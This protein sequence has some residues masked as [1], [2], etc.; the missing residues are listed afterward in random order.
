MIGV[1]SPGKSYWSKQFSYFHFYQIQQLFVVYHIALVQ[2]YDDVWYAYLSVTA[3][4]VL[5]SAA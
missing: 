1:S 5:L 4:C 2:E 3:G